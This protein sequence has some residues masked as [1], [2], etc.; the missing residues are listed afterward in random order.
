MFCRSDDKKEGAVSCSY[1]DGGVETVTSV[2]ATA[3]HTQAGEGEVGAVMGGKVIATG[4]IV[5]SV[6]AGR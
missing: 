5:A 2:L 4:H 3:L 1:F 6:E